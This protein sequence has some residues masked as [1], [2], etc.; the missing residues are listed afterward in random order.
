MCVSSTLRHHKAPGFVVSDSANIR[1]QNVTVHHAGGIG[2]IGQRNRD[3]IVTGCRVTPSR[4][5]MTS[6]TSDATHFVGHTGRLVLSHNL[7]EMQGDD[8]SNIHGIYV[9]VVQV[10][11]AQQRVWVKCVHSQQH[12][13]DFAKKGTQVEFVHAKSMATYGTGTVASVTRLNEE[14]SELALVGGLPRSLVVGD[15]VAELRAYPTVLIYNNTIRNNRARGLLLNT[16]GKTLVANNY[17]HTA[18]AAILFESDAM[19]WFEQ[20]GTRDCKIRGNTF[21]QCAHLG[22][23]YWGDAVIA[24]NPGVT[25]HFN[26]SRYN[27]G[28]SIKQNRFIMFDQARFLLHAQFVARLVWRSNRISRKQAPLAYAGRSKQPTVPYYRIEHSDSVCIDGKC[29]KSN[30][31]TL[32]EDVQPRTARRRATTVPPPP[33]PK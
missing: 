23:A 9:K 13:Y 10:D 20:G 12:G 21:S 7:F 29:M 19:Y 6:T 17:F 5:R 11:H 8:A 25:S 1:I 26:T 32:V 14:V 15:V 2:I 24:F 31:P 30:H 3:M 28:I 18:G 33:P 4:R 22:N 16:R 27:T